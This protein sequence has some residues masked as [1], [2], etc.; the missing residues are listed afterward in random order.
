M[1]VLWT[2]AEQE[3]LKKIFFSF[4]KNNPLYDQIRV[5]NASGQELVRLNAGPENP[6]VVP[7]WELQNKANRYYFK[8]TIKL[9]SNEVYMSP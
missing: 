9:E 4:M 2:S 1:M 3:E 6:I 7:Q 8:D 5:L